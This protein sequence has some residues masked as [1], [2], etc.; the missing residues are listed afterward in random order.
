MKSYNIKDIYPLLSVDNGIIL[1]K[2]GSVTIPFRMYQ[3][4]VYSLSE[5]QINT[6]INEF[7]RAFKGMSDRTII[8]KQDTYVRKRF[9]SDIIKGDS[10]LQVAERN[11]FENAV[12]L[13]HTTVL[14]FSISGLMSLEPSYVKNPLA[15]KEHLHMEDLNRLSS[16]IEEVE[17]AVI[18]LNNLFDTS[19]IRMSEKE[20]KD[21][22]YFY[23]NG[24]TDD[25]SLNDVVFDQQIETAGK[26]GCIF[27]FSGTEYLPDEL[28]STVRDDS[29]PNANVE[30]LAAPLER[31]G[32]HLRYSHIIN[33][34]WEFNSIYRSELASKVRQFGQHQGFD[35]DIAREYKLLDELE[36]NLIKEQNVICNNHFNVILLEESALFAK[37]KEEISQILKVS[38]FNYYMP[39]YENLREIYIGSVLG[40][41]SKFSKRFW[42][43]CDLASSLCLM[44]NQSI[45]KQDP[46]GVLFND[47]IYNTPLFID[48][49]HGR[50]GFKIPAR[51]TIVFASTGG[52]KSVATLNI[53]QQYIEQ[54]VSVVVAE[55]GKS[56]YQL[57]QIYG[58]RSMH[59]DYDGETP[60]GINPF[61]IKGKP[62]REKINTLV[63]LILKFW[64]QKTVMK[65]TNQVVALRN[66]LI[67]YYEKNPEINHSFPDFYYYIKENFNKIADDIDM[68]KDYFDYNSFIHVC[69]EFTAGGFYEN[70]CKES[71][72]MADISDKDFIVFELTQIKKDTFLVSVI[73][74]I[75][76]DVIESK[77]LD[78]GKRGL[79]VFD[80]YAETQTLKDNFNDNN[81][82]ST[83]AFCYQK[84]RK[85]GSAVLAV[86]QS[87]SQLSDDEY[88][89]GIIANTQIL[90]VLPTTESVY[91]SI[92][93]A[94]NIKV[95]SHIALMKS[96]KNQ[97]E[98]DEKYSELFIRFGDL[99]AI[100]VR[101]KLSVERFL[102][103]QTDGGIWKMLQD[104]SKK[105][106]IK[107]AIIQLKQREY[108]KKSIIT[109]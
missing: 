17:N 104:E 101:L 28:S 103:F 8:H 31:L 6:R 78:R 100:V 82:H 37:A 2:S 47:R 49:W 20:I 109:I 69:K 63:N 81:I 98:G 73:M 106:G 93:N 5:E 83:V 25:N 52:G 50:A 4:E 75:L 90:I 58:D 32:V 95:K 102:A 42:F 19:L 89:K 59:I 12:Y 107:N 70:I 40:N 87:P 7:F 56:F 39:K 105:T 14:N 55:F 72:L 13:E 71:E 91:Q 92:I 53:V 86:L 35:K 54:G 38:D 48:L 77:L 65:D 41:E 29:L 23:C 11:C 10:F 44:P 94:F 51:N 46:E 88:S 68:N 61:H 43:L 99:Y 9:N 30:L 62:D 66:L 21:L 79:L 76:L 3:P 16:F 80:E 15:F 74:S 64:R 97:F 1:S 24:Q 57:S 96:Q 60:L 84:L 22:L 67:Y 36:A 85:E 33:Q 18:I 27:A 26:L 34:F 45:Y 108:E